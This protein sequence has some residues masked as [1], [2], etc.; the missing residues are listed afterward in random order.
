MNE[1]TNL[2]SQS[3]MAIALCAAAVYVCRIEGT[4]RSERPLWLKVWTQAWIVTLFIGMIVPIPG[5]GL[6]FSGYFRGI[7]GDLSIT[8]LLLCLWS[9]GHRLFGAAGIERR[10]LRALLVVVGAAALLLY[11]TALG[12][13]DWDAYRLGWGSWWLFSALLLLCGVCAW[14]GLLVL[15]A[16]VALALLAWS[17]GMME[18]GNLWDYLLDPWLSAFA[19]GFILIKSGQ[20]LIK[21]L[22]NRSSH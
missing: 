7:F 20:N 4:H 19:A 21:R 18:S 14:L 22:F 10:E 12:L 8:L 15:P 3:S 1:L 6:A 17:A 9:L 11:P 16:M 2:L 5:T 13:G